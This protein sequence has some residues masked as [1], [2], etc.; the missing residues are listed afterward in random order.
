MEELLRTNDPVLLTFVEALL[1]EAGI[2]HTVADRNMSVIE[3][4]LGILPRRVLVMAEDWE[5]ARGIVTEAGLGRELG[6][7]RPSGS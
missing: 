4:S 5:E 3:G 2:G 1:N 6:D 7:D